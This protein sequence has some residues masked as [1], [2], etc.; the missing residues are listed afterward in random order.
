LTKI[1]TKILQLW[2]K[3]VMGDER[4]NARKSVLFSYEFPR[5]FELPG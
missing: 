2:R 1:A 4:V 5:R 3:K